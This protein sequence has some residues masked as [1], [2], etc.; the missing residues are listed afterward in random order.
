MSTHSIKILIGFLLINILLIDSVVLSADYKLR[1]FRDS[2]CAAIK[3]HYKPE[4]AKSPRVGEFYF[5]NTWNS[6][7]EIMQIQFSDT[8]ANK[9]Q[10]IHLYGCDA[11]GHAY[12]LWIQE[13]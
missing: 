5:T 4:P 12:R 1:T 2:A 7:Y 10:I 11:H 3:N 9:S 13:Y 6:T 8:L